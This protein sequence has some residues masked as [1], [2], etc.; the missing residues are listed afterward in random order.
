MFVYLSLLCFKARVTYTPDL[1]PRPVNNT[2]HSD[3]PSCPSETL[4]STYPPI[5]TSYKN[6]PIPP[7]HPKNP[8]PL[9]APYPKNKSGGGKGHLGR[10]D[11][12]SKDPEH[13]T[14]LQ[15]ML[16]TP[17]CEPGIGGLDKDGVD[18]GFGSFNETA[19]NDFK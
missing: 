16:V 3:F 19:V 9:P 7:L 14:H 2:L 6:H 17:G 4:Y 13:V 11:I 1:S 10:P 15:M 12:C 5:T 8:G 18:G